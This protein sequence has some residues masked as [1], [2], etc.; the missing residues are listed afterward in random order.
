MQDIYYPSA[1][2][3]TTVHACIWRPEGQIKGVYQIIHGMAEYAARY[4][5][6]ARFLNDNGFAVVAEDHLGHGQSVAGKEDYGYFTEGCGVDTVVADIRALTE[7]AKELFPDKPYFI[8]GHSMGSFFCRKYITMYGGELNGAVI[9]GSGWQPRAVVG[10][11]L[12]LTKTIAAK[13]G[14][15]YVSKQ[16]DSLAFGHYNDRFKPNR[17]QFDWLSKNT[18]NVDRYIADELCGIPFTCSGFCGLFGVI[19]EVCTKEAVEK[20]PKKLPVYFVAGNDDPVGNYGKGVK[21]AY[22]MFVKAGVEDV[23]LTLYR[24]ARHEILNDDC[25]PQVMQDIL[26]FISERI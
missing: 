26:E 19:K 15:R 24:D 4:A 12:A 8:M 10:T 20:V 13:H 22:D 18:E 21:K 9:M 3:R 1:D 5:P 11:A 7:K 25:A 14:W 2:G 6:F 17:T 23:S 16:I